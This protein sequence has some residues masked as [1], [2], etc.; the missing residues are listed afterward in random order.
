MSLADAFHGR[1]ILITG[2]LGFLG[3]NLAIKLARY[4]A[5]VTIVDSLIPQFGG[6]FMK[7]R[8]TG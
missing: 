5:N 2:G 4:G 8:A 1:N 7:G 6:S 3:S